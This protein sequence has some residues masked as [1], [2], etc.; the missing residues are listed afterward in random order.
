MTLSLIYSFITILA[1]TEPLVE[2]ASWWH[3][4]NC[5][6]T[7]VWAMSLMVYVDSHFHDWAG[8]T[9]QSVN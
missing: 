4:E 7:D 8:P 6:T 3:S 1:G 9:V 5:I 2:E